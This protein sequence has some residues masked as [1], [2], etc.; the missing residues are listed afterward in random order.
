M[1]MPRACRLL[2]AALLLVAAPVAADD[3]AALEAKL[4]LTRPD[5]PV[6]AALIRKVAMSY[7]G[8]GG[9]MPGV[10]DALVNIAKSPSFFG[11][12]HRLE[13]DLGMAMD[14][15]WAQFGRAEGVPL[16]MAARDVAEIYDKPLE[17]ARNFNRRGYR[18]FD[19]AFVRR[20][21]L[22]ALSGRSR[23]AVEEVRNQLRSVR[24][25]G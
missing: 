8:S 23:E 19:A 16:A 12:A 21:E 1:L 25:R 4:R 10:E 11:P 3:L 20:V 2:T 7:C 5:A 17:A 6:V 24:V 14:I 15:A 9:C 13:E 18:G 22:T